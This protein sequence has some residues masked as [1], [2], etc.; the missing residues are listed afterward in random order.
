VH[1]GLYRGGWT[2]PKSL[3]WVQLGVSP[4]HIVRL[5]DAV[6][7]NNRRCR[8]GCRSVRQRYRVCWGN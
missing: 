5:N 2:T 6:T 1:R 4:K 3:R 7:N 8:R